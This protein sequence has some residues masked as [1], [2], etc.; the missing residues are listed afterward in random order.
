MYKPSKIK[1]PSVRN[2]RKNKKKGEPAYASSPG[3][4]FAKATAD[5][6][7]D[8]P[9]SAEITTD[10]PASAQAAATEPHAQDRAAQETHK[11]IVNEDEQKKVVN[12]PATS[13]AAAYDDS[14]ES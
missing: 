14:E 12:Q 3:P 10:E 2:P 11:P 13:T 5:D 9:A 4:S 7:E 8:K 6:P 1:H